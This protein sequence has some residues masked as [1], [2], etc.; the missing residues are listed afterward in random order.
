MAMLLE[1]SKDAELTAQL[2][3]K[4]LSNDEKRNLGR[5]VFGLLFS[6]TVAPG[7]VQRYVQSPT[8]EEREAERQE[9]LQ[10]RREARGE[11][12]SQEFQTLEDVYNRMRGRPQPP[13]PTTRGMPNM[14]GA[15]P[16][17]AGGPPP[18]TGGPTQ[19]RLMLQ[20]LFP[21]DAIVG[22]AGLASNPAMMPPGMG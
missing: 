18:T 6:P 20:Q 10:R 3:R 14:P 19:S 12:A 8:E 4:D 16:P 17:P 11:R 22:A 2:L 21:N 5:I 15:T 9:A 13:A 7:A 1:V